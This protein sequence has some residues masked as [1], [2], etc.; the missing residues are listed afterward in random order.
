MDQVE[1]VKSKVDI[2][3][4]ISA[5][6]PLKKAGR[7]FAALC[8]FHSEKTPSFMVS[9]ERQVFKCF[10]CGESGD[11]FTFLEKM[12]GWDFREALEEMA[13]KTG[14]KLEGFGRTETTGQKEKLLAI[15]KL[16][17]KF[18]KYLLLKHK[19]AEKARQYLRDRGIDP[20]LWEKFDLGYAPFDWQTLSAFLSKKGYDLADVT[21]AG[22]VVGREARVAREGRRDY[23]DRFRNRLMFPLKDTRGQTLGFAGRIL[24][25][26][27]AGVKVRQEAKY[28]NTPETALY[29]KGS[30]LYGLDLAREA[31]R[32]KNE[33]I[34]VEGEFDVISAHKAGVESVVASKGT[35]LSD[36]QVAMISRMAE[37]TIMCFDTDLAGDAAARRAIELL[38]MA[39][40]TVRVANLGKFKDPDEYCQK[41]PS[42]FRKTLAAA[43]NV[44]DWFIES[45]SRRHNPRSVDGQKKIGREILPILSKISDDLVRAHYIEKLARVLGMDVN[46]V[47]AAVEKKARNLDVLLLEASIPTGNK[48]GVGLE[49]YFLALFLAQDEIEVKIAKMVEPG[50]F[51]DAASQK[52]WR[53]VHGIIGGLR[54]RSTKALLTRLPKEFADFVD[55]LFLINIGPTF[56]D[57]ELWAQEI[58]KVIRRIKEAAIKRELSEISKK[59]KEA[60]VK[61]DNQQVAIL[62]RKFDEMTKFLEEVI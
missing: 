60:Q 34:L 37:V 28:I 58:L 13:K 7:N 41:N 57:R 11:V 62:S 14:V 55:E 2:V 23:Y 52:L 5:Y 43:E 27:Q 1:Q 31:I 54:N 51:V 32:K 17:S 47:A 9:A 35:A 48:G 20:N 30:M 42:G 61:E 8:P 40:V 59:L 18:Y 45:A 3:E 10:G 56:A 24:D 33:V 44:Y 38:D 53:W 46:L 6:L 15:N 12:E 49:K 4:V 26:D 50:E 22:L 29:H 19:V 36:K 16:A 21:S 25:G 39:G